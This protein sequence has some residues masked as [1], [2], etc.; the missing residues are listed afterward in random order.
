[1]VNALALLALWS[2]ISYPIAMLVR[3]VEGGADLVSLSV[4]LSML[5]G[6]S[7]HRA[8]HRFGPAGVALMLGLA[9]GAAIGGQASES[10]GSGVF[11]LGAAFCLLL[12][13]AAA[14]TSGGLGLLASRQR[15]VAAAAGRAGRRGPLWPALLF[16]FGD[17]G[18]GAV[19]SV[20]AV[21]Y[22]VDEVGLPAR[23]VGAAMGGSLAI[24]G[25]GS[26]PAGLLADRIGPLPVRVLSVI[27]YAGAFAALAGA[28]WMNSGAV[29]VVL[30][31]LGVAGAGLYP[32]TLI[33]AARAG[34]GAT[35]MGGVHVAG[36]VGYLFGI[37][38]A[39]TM[40]LD[41][42]ASGG[43]Q[44]IMV[45]FATLY[46]LVNIPAVLGLAVTQR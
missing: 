23:F 4:L 40:L 34:G 28:S 41:D 25:L 37:V 35:G 1:M 18:L 5:E 7:R 42:P 20:T 12:A 3:L 45:V 10:L 13:V 17:R 31:V 22:L 21:L 6:G 32:S 11:L 19:L 14:G 33:V 2:P 8:G 29:V 24:L 9:T 38:A 39:G 27:G 44:V 15:R 43:Y 26:W 36:S 30:I 16:A 46:V